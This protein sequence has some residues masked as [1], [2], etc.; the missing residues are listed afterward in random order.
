MNQNLIAWEHLENLAWSDVL[1]VL[2]VLLLARLLI[3][4]VQWQLRRMAESGS[5]GRRLTILPVL[6]SPRS[7]CLSSQ[8]S[9]PCATSSPS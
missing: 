3:V 7:P 8:P 2:A 1:V 5:P 6:I 9:P 4:G